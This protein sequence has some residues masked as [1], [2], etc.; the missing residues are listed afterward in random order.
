MAYNDTEIS[1]ARF[2]SMINYYITN[3]GRNYYIF[4]WY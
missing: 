2:A 1:S 4:N 3:H